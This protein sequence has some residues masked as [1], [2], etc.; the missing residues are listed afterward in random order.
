M[1]MDSP[2]AVSMLSKD[3]K[4]WSGSASTFKTRSNNKHTH[5]RVLRP[6]R[7]ELA[8]D[9][10]T[11]SNAPKNLKQSRPTP[12]TKPGQNPQRL[13]LVQK[14]L[15]I[16]TLTACAT[17]AKSA[18]QQT[19]THP[20]CTP[21][22]RGAL[23]AFVY[24]HCAANHEVRHFA[25][26][27]NRFSLAKKARFDL[28]RVEFAGR[29]QVIQNLQQSKMSAEALVQTEHINHK[30][31]QYAHT[32]CWTGIGDSARTYRKMKETTTKEVKQTSCVCVLESSDTTRDMTPSPAPERRIS[33]S[34]KLQS[35]TWRWTKRQLTSSTQSRGIWPQNT[36]DV[37]AHIC[38]THVIS[39]Q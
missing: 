11:L 36:G 21:S 10:T 3:S 38:H 22:R 19:T 29:K 28:G 14:N 31:T 26:R 37:T 2:V 18:T 15:L 39:N 12:V 33:L 7:W 9:Q 1:T 20:K 27:T 16:I 17:Q 30:Q 13:W 25:L 32:C 34:R 6:L 8:I 5:R 4:F 35:K 23:F 24:A